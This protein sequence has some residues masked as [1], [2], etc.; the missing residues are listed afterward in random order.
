MR[1]AKYVFMTSIRRASNI[2]L[3]KKVTVKVSYLYSTYFTRARDI[4]VN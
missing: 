2:E 4:G 3:I 1:K